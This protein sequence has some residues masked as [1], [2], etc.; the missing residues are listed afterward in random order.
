MRISPAVVSAPG[1]HTGRQRNSAWSQDGY[2]SPAPPVLPAG[3]PTPAGGVLKIGPLFEVFCMEVQQI[4]C[5]PRH[6]NCNRFF[7]RQ[8]SRVPGTGWR[9]LPCAGSDCFWLGWVPR[10]NLSPG[11]Y[12]Q[13]L[14]GFSFL[15]NWDRDPVV[16]NAMISKCFVIEYIIIQFV[17]L[18]SNL[19][20]FCTA[21]QK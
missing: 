9:S 17:Q 21:F 14:E 19:L 3:V 8:Q 4:I 10:W 2:L 12:P 11:S 7:P 5:R 16:L 15:T 18:P 1:R 20:R 13:L 6:K